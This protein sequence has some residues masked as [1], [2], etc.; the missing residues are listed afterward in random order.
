MKNELISKNNMYSQFLYE[1][2]YS[3]ENFI[4]NSAMTI[5]NSRKRVVN[6][7]GLVQPEIKL[8]VFILLKM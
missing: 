4:K 1:W 8:K 6:K 5:I 2:L 7:N 3:V